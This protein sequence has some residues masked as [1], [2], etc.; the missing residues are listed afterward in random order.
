[1]SD[2]TPVYLKPNVIAEPLV[3]QWYAWTHLISPATA[4]MNIANRHLSIM[5]SYVQAPHVHA[6][7]VKN[8]DMLGGPFMDY[9]GRNRVEDVRTLV[10]RVHSEQSHMLEFAAGIK[11][12]EE[13][14]EEKAKGYSL[15]PLY[16]EVP[17]VLKG[18]VELF[19][20]LR[21]Q[22]TYRVLE[23]LLYESPYYDRSFQSICLSLVEDDSDRPFSLSTPRFGDEGGYHLQIPFEHAGIDAMFRMKKEP[24]PLGWI[25]EQMGITNGNSE[26]FGEFFTEN[27][28]E[29]YEPYTGDALRMR[30][31]GHACLLIETRDVSILIDP[32]ISYEYHSDLPRYTYADLPEKVDYVVI[33]HNHQDHILLETMLQLRHKVGTFV[34]P[35]NGTGALQDPSL[36]LCLHRLGFDNVAELDEMESLEIDGGSIRSLPFFGEHA[37]LA[38]RTKSA[39]LVTLG[40]STMAFAADSCNIDPY[41]YRHVHRIVGNIDVLFLGM[42]CDGAPLSWLYGPLISRPLERKKDH[43]RRLAG[44]NYERAIDLVERFGCKE[45]YVYAMGMEPWLNY[46]MAKKYT[47]DS[48]P[49]I[50]SKKMIEAC[51]E[52]GVLADLLYGEREFLRR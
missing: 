13:M 37:D 32:V 45:A 44:S 4:A 48:N 38:I 42:E 3:T 35:R 12:L 16:A 47:D 2:N 10:D 7:A 15:E 39:F 25:R 21:D 46:I 33:T 8:P 18:Y 51:R 22:P 34:V 23:P 20:D 11:Q 41:L 31:F 50:A 52:K 49:I 19:Y 26:A 40:D 27:A 14:L 5:G 30:Y 17:D 9:G 28:P 36:K 24:K 1:M 6:A 43:S 29:P